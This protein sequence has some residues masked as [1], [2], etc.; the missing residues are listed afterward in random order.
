VN[1]LAQLLLERGLVGE[2]QLHAALDAQIATGG[3][4]GPALVATGAISEEQLV[5]LHA[6]HRGMP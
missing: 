4:L 1:H 6:E 2:E 5:G 3:D